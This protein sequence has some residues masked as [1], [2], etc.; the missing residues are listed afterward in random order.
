[1]LHSFNN[2]LLL[3]YFFD[4]AANFSEIKIIRKYLKL[5]DNQGYNHSFGKLT[6]LLN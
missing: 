2:F 5:N 1:L 3:L 4:I 6:F